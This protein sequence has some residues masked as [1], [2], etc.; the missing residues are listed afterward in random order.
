VSLSSL[1][2]KAT[3]PE[4]SGYTMLQK[5]DDDVD[6]NKGWEILIIQKF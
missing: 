5:F 2:F 3:T 4:E 6:I 1:G